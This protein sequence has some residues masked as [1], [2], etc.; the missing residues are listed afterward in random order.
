MRIRLIIA[1]V[2][3]IVAATGCSHWQK[4]DGNRNPSQVGGAQLMDEK[5][6]T[7]YDVLFTDPECR[8]YSYV[9]E[10]KSTGGFKLS[11]KPKNVYC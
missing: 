5:N 10:T 11:N 2:G 4:P 9:E 7:V 3:L 8:R 1:N 6:G